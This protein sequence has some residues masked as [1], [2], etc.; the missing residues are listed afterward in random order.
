MKATKE[1][2]LKRWLFKLV[3]KSDNGLKVIRGRKL[4]PRNMTKMEI[5]SDV[6]QQIED[7]ALSIFTDMTNSGATFQQ[8][9]A[10]IYLS[11]VENTVAALKEEQSK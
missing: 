4:A 9:L 10:A 2:L 1:I 3:V 8:T 11:G 6:R 7:T 5:S